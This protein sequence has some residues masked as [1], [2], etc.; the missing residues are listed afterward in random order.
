MTHTRTVVPHVYLLSCAAHK[1]AAQFLDDLARAL[2]VLARYMAETAP[3]ADD[4][5]KG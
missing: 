3:R 1:H 5:P 2:Y 4:G